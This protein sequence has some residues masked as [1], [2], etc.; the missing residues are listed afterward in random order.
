MLAAPGLRP[1]A[2]SHRPSAEKESDQTARATGSWCQFGN[3][4]PSVRQTTSPMVHVSVPAAAPAMVPGSLRGRL[5]HAERAGYIGSTGHAIDR[6][7]VAEFV[8]IQRF[9]P[10]VG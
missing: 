10:R 1:A 9:G 8:R 5:R 7:L 4:T 6:G 2:A 3:P